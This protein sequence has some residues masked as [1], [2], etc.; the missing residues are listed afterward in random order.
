EWN[1]P[2]AAIDA[3]FNHYYP[4]EREKFNIFGGA[5][6]YGHPYACSGIIN[7]LHLMQALKYKNKPMGLTAIAGAG[8]VGMAISI[9]YLGVKNA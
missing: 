5:L 2:F 9:E 6:A 7:I 3:L 8:G 1:E 4:E